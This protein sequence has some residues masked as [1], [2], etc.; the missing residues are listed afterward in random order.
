MREAWSEI[1]IVKNTER[2]DFLFNFGTESDEENERGITKIQAE[3]GIVGRQH[4]QG[5]YGRRI[6]KIPKDL[7]LLQK[8]D[9]TAIIFS[10]GM[11]KKRTAGLYNWLHD[12]YL[13]DE[14]EFDGEPFTTWWN[15]REFAIATKD[16]DTAKRLL[17][18][19]EQFQNKN[20]AIGLGFSRVL[21]P[22]G[23][24]ILILSETP[25]YIIKDALK[26]DR[27]KSRLI[28]K[29]KKLRIENL[30]KKKNKEVLAVIPRWANRNEKRRTRYPLVYWVKPKDESVYQEGW[31]TV[32]DIKLWAVKDLG[33]ILKQ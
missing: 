23:F 31:Y 12:R 2:Q 15:E 16:D 24:K 7:K 10:P 28:S 20:V 8:D 13:T 17:N 33:P 1:E 32:E 26:A 18:L 11:S 25:D 9:L 29:A 27:H 22:A 6:T 3:F 14:L 21:R 19:W 4:R 30:L 5:I